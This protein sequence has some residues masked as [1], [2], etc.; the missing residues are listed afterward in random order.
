MRQEIAGLVI[1]FRNTLELH[2]K[3][4]VALSETEK[5]CEK[6][7]KHFKNLKKKKKILRQFLGVQPE[8]PHVAPES[9]VRNNS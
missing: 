5:E 3:V 4:R 6:T 2:E 1:V 8:S 7:G 9:L